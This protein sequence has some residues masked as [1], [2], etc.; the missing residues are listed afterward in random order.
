[1][2][3]SQVF[4]KLKLSEQSINTLLDLYLVSPLSLKCAVVCS[5]S[6]TVNHPHPA[7]SLISGV[8]GGWY[9]ELKATHPLK[10]W[11][12][13]FPGMRESLDRDRG[14]KRLTGQGHLSGVQLELCACVHP[15]LRLET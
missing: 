15:P 12:L 7:P 6:N 8:E 1:M 14:V 10:R 13:D 2:G 9:E 3:G 4:E 5:V 11:D